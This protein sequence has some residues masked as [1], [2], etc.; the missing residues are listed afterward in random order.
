MN[1]NLATTTLNPGDELLFHGLRLARGPIRTPVRCRSER[2]VICDYRVG[3]VDRH[4]IVALETRTR[5]PVPA[6]RSGGQESTIWCRDLLADL[7][8]GRV[9][10]SEVALSLDIVIPAPTA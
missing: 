2:F 8:A 6:E 10:V 7:E 4:L 3:G 1:E 9:P 5:Q